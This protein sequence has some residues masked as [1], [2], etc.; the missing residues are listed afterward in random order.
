MRCRSPRLS[1]PLFAMG[2]LIGHAAL[3]ISVLL[4]TAPFALLAA[5]VEPQGQNA[6]ITP[7]PVFAQVEDLGFWHQYKW[8]IVGAG[9]LLTL[10]SVLIA[11][12]L[13][14]RQRK[15][16]AARLPAESEEFNRSISPIQGTGKNGERCIAVSRDMTEHDLSVKAMENSEKELTQLTVRL[17]NIQD[18]E[19]RR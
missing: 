9:A 3:F 7:A 16:A 19:R 4:T 5:T 13:L 12:L 15:K 14:E 17:F 11:A 1:R 18:E 6:A 10:E 8:R 2:V